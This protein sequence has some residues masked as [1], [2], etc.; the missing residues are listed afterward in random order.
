VKKA[1]LVMLI[2]LMALTPC[3]AQELEPDGIFSLDGT[4]WLRLG[5]NES[6]HKMGFYDGEIYLIGKYYSE[7][8]PIEPHEQC[9][10]VCQRPDNSICFYSTLPFLAIFYY[11]YN[12]NM[13][14]THSSGFMLPHLSIGFRFS[15]SQFIG[16]PFIIVNTFKKVDSDWVPP[17][18]CFLE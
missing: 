17:E 2:G 5:S 14:Q 8:F 16:P 13:Q 9:S 12:S 7:Q 11:D 4:L 18:M 6:N 3:L 10:P 1:I 15:P